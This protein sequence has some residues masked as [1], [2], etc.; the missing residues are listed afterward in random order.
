MEAGRIML[1]RLDAL[2]AQRLNVAF[3]TTLASRS[4]VCF[5]Q[6]CVHLL[7]PVDVKESA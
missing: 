1:R 7:N 2:T 4:F 5:R 6:G 3:E